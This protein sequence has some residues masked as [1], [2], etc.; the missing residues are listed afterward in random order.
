M[1]QSIQVPY[2]DILI[3]LQ[4]TTRLG[5]ASKRFQDWMVAVTGGLPSYQPIVITDFGAGGSGRSDDTSALQQAINQAVANGGATVLL[6]P[7]V[8]LIGTVTFPAGDV[9]ITLL[10]AGES[11]VL[12]RRAV[13]DDGVGMLDIRG[14]HVS[15]ENL[16]I[17][18]DVTS[19]QGLLYGSGFVGA[20]PNDPMAT[21]L[22]KNSS[23]WVHGPAADFSCYRVKFTHS[24][25]YA[26]LLDATTGGITDVRVVD[27]VFCLN[28]P[29]LFGTVAGQENFGSWTGGCFYKGIGSA[30]NPG[31]V[32]KRFMVS[33]CR[34]LRGTGNQLWGHLS[35]LDELHEG[36]Q[37]FDNLFEDIGLDGILMGGVSGGAVNNNVFHRIGYI[38]R[39]D[40]DRPVPAWLPNLNATAL[41]S[42]G[43]VKGVNYQGNSFLSVNGGNCDLD[44]HAQSSLTGNLMKIPYPS[45]AEFADDDIAIT[46]PANSGSASYGVNLSNSSNTQWGAIEVNVVGNT[47]IN[48][49]AGSARFYAARR[50]LFTSNNVIAPPDSV[51][52]PVA[53]GPIGP[54]PNQRCYDNKIFGNSIDYNA[55]A[56]AII[57]DD[58]YSA[59]LPAEKNTVCG[60]VPLT[61]SGTAASEFLKSPTSGSVTY[62]ETPWFV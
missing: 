13:L 55:A 4:E 32:V 62:L 38:T 59:F 49:R 43:L 57:E 53:M 44:S 35:S 56:P 29:H 17:E 22:T 23:V 42:S 41:D 27:S 46:G 36:L 40:T 30:A 9:P 21:S 50:C 45:E 34:F 31:C 16:V 47:F 3:E 37:F 5:M 15:L 14:S 25:G 60:N 11:T 54:G 26:C 52:P 20:M 58:T 24:G 2:R 51:V 39:T 7:G 19:P 28:R 61:P 8:Y 10:G 12:K 33:G 6:P 48:L 1:N 18:G